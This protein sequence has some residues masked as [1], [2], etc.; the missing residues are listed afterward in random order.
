MSKY[1]ITAIVLFLF[2][3]SGNTYDFLLITVSYRELPAHKLNDL[4]FPNKSELSIK[5]WDSANSNQIWM[6]RSETKKQKQKRP[7][8]KQ[9]QQ[10]NNQP[11]KQTNKQTNKQT[12][13]KAK[14][15]NKNKNKPK[16]SKHTNKQ[17]KQKQKQ[18]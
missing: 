18:L 6:L 2:S 1:L 5:M 11:T 10:P 9:T 13:T 12:K 17:T 14:N 15:K 16:K 7:P 3:R 4:G 8:K